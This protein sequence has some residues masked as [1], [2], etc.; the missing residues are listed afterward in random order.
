M[1]IRVFNIILALV[2]FGTIPLIVPTIYYVYWLR[3]FIDS[4]FEGQDDVFDFIVGK[5]R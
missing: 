2:V 5:F 3:D 4:Q 1:I